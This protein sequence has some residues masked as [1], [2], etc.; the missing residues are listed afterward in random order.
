MI[1]ITFSCTLDSIAGVTH[2]ELS[3]GDLQ[4][5]GVTAN[6]QKTSEEYMKDLLGLQD[7]SVKQIVDSLVSNGRN[8]NK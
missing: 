6:N 5:S 4:V 2:F 3:N 8:K 1:A 7:A